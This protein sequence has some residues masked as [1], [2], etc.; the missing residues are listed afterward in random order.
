MPKP[1]L[2]P[3]VPVLLVSNS[4]TAGTGYGQQTAQLALR[5]KKAGHPVAVASNYGQ[6]ATIGEWRGIKVLP[7]GFDMYSNDVVA[8]YW[9]LWSAENNAEAVV[10]T[11]FDV[12][13]FNGAPWDRIPKVISWV[14]IDHAP[15]PEKVARGCGATTLPR[16]R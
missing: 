13:V 3:K 8:A 14:P 1:T 6:E 7:R 2:P 4:P 9:E 11:L 16:S 15:L 5:L 12:W 10:L